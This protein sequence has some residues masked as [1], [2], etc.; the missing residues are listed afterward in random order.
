MSV[1][2]APPPVGAPGAAANPNP[3]EATDPRC[4]TH[5]IRVAPMSSSSTAADASVAQ[6][7]G[8]QLI[9]KLQ[10]RPAGQ[11]QLGSHFQQQ[12]SKL[13]MSLAVRLLITVCIPAMGQGGT[14]CYTDRHV[15]ASRMLL[16]DAVHLYWLL[17]VFTFAMCCLPCGICS[18]PACCLSRGGA[19]AA[20]LACPLLSEN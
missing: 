10:V 1:Q 2:S 16:V 11:N 9:Y 18:I 4:V 13:A 17:Q 19:A 3:A 15:D 20:A 6:D 12:G 8:E 7:L 14:L 5:T